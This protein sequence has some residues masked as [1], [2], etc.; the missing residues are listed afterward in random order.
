MYDYIFISQLPTYYSDG[1]LYME[2]DGGAGYLTLSLP[3]LCKLDT[4]DTSITT[5]SHTVLG[6]QQRKTKDDMA[7]YKSIDKILQEK[8]MQSATYI[9]HILTFNVRAK[10]MGYYKGEEQA[11]VIITV[12]DNCEILREEW[13]SD[14]P[15]NETINYTYTGENGTEAVGR[16]IVNKTNIIKS[17]DFSSTNSVNI[18]IKV[19]EYLDRSNANSPKSSFKYTALVGALAD[20]ATT[21]LSNAVLFVYNETNKLNNVVTLSDF[22]PIKVST[23]DPISLNE[24]EYSVEYRYEE[25]LPKNTV[26]VNLP[27][28]YSWVNRPVTFTVSVSKAATGLISSID[29]INSVLNISTSSS[30]YTGSLQPTSTVT[31]SRKK[32]SDDDPEVKKFAANGTYQNASNATYTVS[33]SPRSQS[34]RKLTCTLPEGEYTVKK[35]IYTVIGEEEVEIVPGVKVTKSIYGYNTI[36]ETKTHHHSYSCYSYESVSPNLT[37]STYTKTYN[38]TRKV[39]NGT[40]EIPEVGPVQKSSGS[41][42]ANIWFYEKITLRAGTDLKRE[43]FNRIRNSAGTILSSTLKEVDAQYDRD[44]YVQ[45]TMSIQNNAQPSKRFSL[46]KIKRQISLLKQQAWMYIKQ[47]M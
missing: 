36:T 26:N 47:A 14:I 1:I 40:R 28:G 23:L 6:E 9:D 11:P 33:Y 2:R 3:A 10:N 35:K 31:I 4:V 27:S 5:V 12:A 18:T 39:F 19:R 37:W 17:V 13:A 42:P 41:N 20:K 16:F 8:G 46:G 34:A 32:T 15:A 30:S 7:T 38:V 22:V 24:D 44:I 45:T 25:V 43:M 29:L 21:V